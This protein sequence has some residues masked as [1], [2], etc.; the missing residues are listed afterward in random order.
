MIIDVDPISPELGAAQARGTL[1]EDFGSDLI[2]CRLGSFNIES[3]AVDKMMKRISGHKSLVFDLRGNP[4]GRVDTLERFVGYFFDHEVKVGDFKMRKES[5]EIK[6]KPRKPNAFSG[7]LI[8]LVDSQSSSAAEIFARL[9]Q[10]E[11]RG[12]VVGDHSSGRVM[13]SRR[14]DY[15]LE[16]SGDPVLYGLMITDAD[17]VMT[18]GKSLEWV[19]VAPD[20]LILPTGDDLINRRDPAL[21]YAVTLAGVKLEPEKAGRLFATKDS[22]AKH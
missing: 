6:V 3:E 1:Y 17:I 21:A 16:G 22:K 9:V 10:L 12:T 5:K 19:G 15:E 4:G 20:K 2:V 8:V 7:N 11:K 13:Q 14:Y 18:D